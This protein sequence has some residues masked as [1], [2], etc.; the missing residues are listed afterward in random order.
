MSLKPQ[1]SKQLGLW[2][3]TSLVVGGMIGSGIFSIPTALAPY[4]GI[5]LLGWGVASASALILAQIFSKLSKVIPSKGGPY[6]YS[7]VAFGDLTAFIVAWGYLISVWASNAAITITFVSYLSVFFPALAENNFLAGLVCVLTLWFLTAINSHSVKSAGQLQLVSTILKIVPILTITI[8]GFFF[9]Q[10]EHFTPF[11]LSDSSSLKAIT[12]TTAFC[13]FAF[14]GLEAATIPAGNIKNPKKT[15]P[16]ATMF[17]TVVV[18]LIYILSSVSLFGILPPDQLSTSVAP[19][20]DAAANIL[21]ENARY[22]IAAGACISAFGALNGWILIQGQ[23]PMA[24]A[25]DGFLPKIFSKTNKNNTPSFGI[26]IS[27]III[28]LLLVANQSKG[29]NNLYSFALLLT[30]VTLLMSYITS[31]AAFTHFSI[32][33]KFGFSATLKN[34]AL[35]II[36]IL[37]SVWMFIGSGLEANLWGFGGVVLGLPIYFW[38]KKKN[39]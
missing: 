31:A 27:S 29:L 8:A 19:Y 38:R 15:I 9:F 6:A 34:M 5:S 7:K 3:T 16:R 35:G 24:M 11:N 26:I 28:T 4:G 1:K 32:K 25:A 17:G 21:G 36:G 13:L 10:V 14:M 18:T 12:I 2:T 37:F 39:Q 23:L 22:L 30:A 33:N 20:G